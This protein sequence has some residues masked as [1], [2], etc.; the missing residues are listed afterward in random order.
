[1]AE[2]QQERLRH[3][4]ELPT[5]RPLT[6]EEQESLEGLR[7]EYGYVTLRKARAYALLSLRGGRSLL[8]DN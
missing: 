7:R 4:S 1:M 3:L 5:Q 6:E 8:S 2:D